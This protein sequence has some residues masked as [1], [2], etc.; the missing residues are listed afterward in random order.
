M[1]VCWFDV[2]EEER[3]GSMDGRVKK[4][5]KKALTFFGWV[6][7]WNSVVSRVKEHLVGAI[8]DLVLLQKSPL[9]L[10]F[11]ARSLDV[12]KGERDSMGILREHP[13]LQ[14]MG[15]YILESLCT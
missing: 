9:L 7:C 14:C 6:G 13:T 4:K 3:D 1:S 12:V 15:S 11:L 2:S 10:P 5:K 8:S